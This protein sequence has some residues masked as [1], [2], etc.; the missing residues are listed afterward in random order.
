MSLLLDTAHRA[1]WVLLVHMNVRHSHTGLHLCTLKL[2]ISPKRKFTRTCP[3]TNTHTHTHMHT[4]THMLDCEVLAR[5]E[6]VWF[7]R[8]EVPSTKGRPCKLCIYKTIHL[9]NRRCIHRHCGM[10]YGNEIVQPLRA[11]ISNCMWTLQGERV[12]EHPKLLC[13]NTDTLLM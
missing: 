9:S 3:H 2:T 12:L 5:E 7:Y 10:R 8:V 6:Y 4:N 13:N 11:K 1:A